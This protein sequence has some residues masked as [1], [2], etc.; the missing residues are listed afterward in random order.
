MLMQDSYH[1]EGANRFPTAQGACLIGLCTGSFAAVA[2]SASSTVA[3]LITTGV[4]AT[5]VAFRTGLYS[6]TYG[7]DVQG[8]TDASLSWSI[9]VGMQEEE[10][11]SALSSFNATKVNHDRLHTYVCILTPH[12]RPLHS[13]LGRT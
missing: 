12:Y 10:V 13:H 9:T 4:E 11:S 3:E 8:S 5:L 6:L 7:F 1:S 2:V